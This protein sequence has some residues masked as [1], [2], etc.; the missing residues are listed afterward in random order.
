[1]ALLLQVLGGEARA[2]GA[3]DVD[4]RVVGAG[5]SHGRPNATNGASRCC[6]H[7]ACGVPV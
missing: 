2:G 6:S 7:A 4:P 3:V 5:S 1:M